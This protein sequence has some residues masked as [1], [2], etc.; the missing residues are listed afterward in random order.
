MAAI[1]PSALTLNTI[2]AD[3]RKL[4][5]KAIF[6]QKNKIDSIH[7]LYS[8]IRA[9]EDVGLY[10]TFGLLMK[11]RQGCS[12]TADSSAKMTLSKKTWNP[13]AW[14][15]IIDTCRSDLDGTIL[16]LA[17]K[18]GLDANDLTGTVVEQLVMAQLVPALSL[19][20][21][22]YAW[23]GDTDAANFNDSPAGELSNSVDPNYFNINDGFFKLLADIYA[24]ESARRTTITENAETTY[25][26]QTLTASEC[27][28]YIKSVYDAAPL[29]LKAQQDQQ[30]LVTQA[31]FDG[32]LEDLAKTY[33]YNNAVGMLQEGGNQLK[34]RGVPV[35][36]VPEWDNVIKSYMD[37]GT[38][39]ASPNR[40]VYTTKSNLAIGLES[41]DGGI[42]YVASNYDPRTRYWR[43]EASDKFDFLILDDTLVQVGI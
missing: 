4:I 36:A 40:I 23:F 42:N 24:S 9:A 31:I 19:D 32:Y 22:R 30:I 43:V 7:T 41:A 2:N 20:L 17:Q 5:K 11:A 29:K 35:I 6:E 39:W 10:G 13:T 25:A 16:Q 1:N 28:A 18:L 37:S 26:N 8:G 27:H 14:E 38:Y 33:G 21:F 34:Y 12:P 15:V 3:V